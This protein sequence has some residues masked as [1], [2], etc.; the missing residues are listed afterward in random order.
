M[1]DKKEDDCFLYESVNQKTIL[2]MKTNGVKK[3]YMQL[4]DFDLKRWKGSNSLIEG[5]LY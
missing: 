3:V 4:L 2:L 5:N 1:K